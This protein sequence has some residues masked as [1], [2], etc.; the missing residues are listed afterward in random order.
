[1]VNKKGVQRLLSSF[2]PVLYLHS[3]M[4][5]RAPRLSVT[6]RVFAAA[7]GG[8][9]LSAATTVCLALYLPTT[10]S[11]AVLT[12]TMISFVIFVCAAIWVFSVSSARRAWMGL[13]L[14]TGIPG[15]ILLISY[16]TAA[17]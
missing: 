17:E 14:A 8:Y 15:G 6:S 10:R 16:L 12:A 9:A 7:I 13:F 3:A 4:K 11:E 1:M 2:S 5:D